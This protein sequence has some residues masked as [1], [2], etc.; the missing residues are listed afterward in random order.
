MN[1]EAIYAAAL[2]YKINRDNQGEKRWDKDADC[3]N[4][5]MAMM[6]QGL[7]GC[8]ARAGFFVGAKPDGELFI[9][10]IDEEITIGTYKNFSEFLKEMIPA[11][12]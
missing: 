12:H 9:V 8:N 7:T 2:Q 11:P 5:F 1:T 10:N 6:K 4:L 3:Q